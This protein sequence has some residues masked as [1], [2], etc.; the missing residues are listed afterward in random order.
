MLTGMTQ[1]Q[2]SG[3]PTKRIEFHTANHGININT[4]FDAEYFK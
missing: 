1:C 2:G 3:C 4:V